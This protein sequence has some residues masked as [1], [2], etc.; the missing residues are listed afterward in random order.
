MGEKDVNF[1]A[2]A[3]SAVGYIKARNLESDFGE[4]CGG[5]KPPFGTKPC[6]PDPAATMKEVRTLGDVL[7]SW[8]ASN[9]PDDLTVIAGNMAEAIRALLAKLGGE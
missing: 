3:K 8:D 2:W 6:D 1:E 5:W 7:G 4:W 9:N